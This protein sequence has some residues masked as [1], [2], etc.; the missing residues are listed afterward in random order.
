MVAGSGANNLTY[1][2]TVTNNGPSDVTGASFSEILTLPVGVTTTGIFISDGNL[3]GFP[4]ANITWDDIDTPAGFSESLIIDLTVTLQAEEGMDV[5]DDTVTF[6][7]STGNETIINTGDD[8]AAEATSVRWP[9]ATFEVFKEY[10]EEPAG[11][12]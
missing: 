10:V 9:E 6:T 12:V 4:G 7:G 5:I 3:S 8:S 1:T 11:P 2:I